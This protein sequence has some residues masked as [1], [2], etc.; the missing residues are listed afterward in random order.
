MAQAF[1]P[2]WRHI[3]ANKPKCSIIIS[4]NE[5]VLL[6]TNSF[7]YIEK[8]KRMKFLNPLASCCAGFFV[9]TDSVG[10]INKAPAKNRGLR[11]R[12]IDKGTGLPKT[13]LALYNIMQRTGPY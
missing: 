8:L 7:L 2:E 13:G 6:L 12:A 4:V 5:L 1:N 11:N 9:D 3:K 10:E